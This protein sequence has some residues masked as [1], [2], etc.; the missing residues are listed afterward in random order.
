MIFNQDLEKSHKASSIDNTKNSDF[1]WF[2][3]SDLI[4]GL[5]SID[6]TYKEKLVPGIDNYHMFP[7]NNL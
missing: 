3:Y 4:Q 2:L 6:K 1:C 5:E 7:I